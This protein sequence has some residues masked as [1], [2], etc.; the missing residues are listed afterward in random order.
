MGEKNKPPPS[1]QDFIPFAF[2][3]SPNQ[4]TTPPLPNRE[5]QNN[6]GSPYSPYT[7][8]GNF[9]GTPRNFSP[10]NSRS[11][12][13]PRNF[14]PRSIFSPHRSANSLTPRK[15]SGSYQNSPTFRNSRS[16]FDSLRGR[17]YSD[18]SFD[19]GNASSCSDFIDT[20]CDLNDSSDSR[21]FNDSSFELRLQDGG[22]Y[23]KYLHPSFT[24][25]PWEPLRRQRERQKAVTEQ[26]V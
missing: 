22:D 15:S 8:S 2:E 1:L 3:L 13:S 12:F 10:R 6:R 18:R 9:R 4:S 26:K 14:S 21:S 25:D 17:K 11:N 7:N 5:G 19:I 16:D 23:L 20:S 24:E